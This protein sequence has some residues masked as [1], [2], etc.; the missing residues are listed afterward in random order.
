MSKQ[1][2]VK[3]GYTVG[4]YTRPATTKTDQLTPEEIAKLIEDYQEVTNIRQIPLETHLR[5]FIKDDDGNMKFRMGGKLFR[6]NGIDEG[7]VMLSNGNTKPWS[8]QLEGTVFYKKMTDAEIKQSFNNIIDDL[9]K[10]IKDQKTL[11]NQL[12]DE[13]NESQMARVKT[14]RA[15]AKA[16]K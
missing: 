14:K 12:K 16:K 10:K 11:I 7:Y 6:N 9:N 2:G 5:Y 3:S 8:V 15:T 13:L 4:E 1:S